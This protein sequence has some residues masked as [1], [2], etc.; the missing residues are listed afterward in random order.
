MHVCNRTQLYDRSTAIYRI[1][2]SAVRHEYRPISFTINLTHTRINH[3]TNPPKYDI[4]LSRRQRT[5]RHIRTPSSCDSHIYIHIQKPPQRLFS[6]G[7]FFALTLLG[8]VRQDA[9][10][11]C[12]NAVQLCPLGIIYVKSPQMASVKL[13]YFRDFR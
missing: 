5:I 9:V 11:P 7:A 8:R 6:T 3:L 4:F 10:H 2:G 1:S 13:R 12:I